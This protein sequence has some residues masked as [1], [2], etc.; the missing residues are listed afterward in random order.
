MSKKGFETTENGLFDS[1]SYLQPWNE[2]SLANSTGA[3]RQRF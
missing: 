1:L 3:V 2:K